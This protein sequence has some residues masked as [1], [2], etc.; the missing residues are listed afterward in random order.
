MKSKRCAPDGC[1]RRRRSRDRTRTESLL[2]L[3]HG[4]LRGDLSVQKPPDRLERILFVDALDEVTRE[5]AQSFLT[6][7]NISASSRAYRAF[8]FDPGFAATAT[9]DEISRNGTNLSIPLYI[10]RGAAAGTIADLPAALLAWRESSSDL[11][12]AAGEVFGLLPGR[13]MVS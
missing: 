6:P 7:A 3:A 2:Q 13:E 11:R 4:G 10:K 8:A 1:S 5:R 12:V 9:L